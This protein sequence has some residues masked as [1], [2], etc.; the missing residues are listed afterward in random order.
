M[1]PAS[2]A[3]TLTVPSRILYRG[4]DLLRLTEREMQ[5]VRGRSLAMVF[6]DPSTCLDPTLTI[7]DQFESPSPL[8]S[9]DFQFLFFQRRGGCVHVRNADEKVLP[10]LQDVAAVQSAGRSRS[11]ERRVGKECR[12]RWS[13]YH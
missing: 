5:R 12:S 9:P 4:R 8:L 2:Q 11:E 13:P 3:L 7:G 10:D 6:Q 1:A